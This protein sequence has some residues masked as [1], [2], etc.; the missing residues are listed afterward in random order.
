MSPI[1]FARAWLPVAMALGAIALGACGGGGTSKD[2]GAL[3]TIDAPASIEVTSPAF[4]DGAAIPRANTCDG[5]GGPPTIRW[6]AVPAAA[7][8]VAVVVDDPDAPRGTFR[9]W[10]AYDIP[11]SARG[12]AS[13]QH[14]GTEVGNDGGKP[15]YTGPCPPKG[16][17]PHHY[18]FRLFALDVPRLDLG[19]NA[20]VADVET[21][22]S[23]HAIAQ[24]E[25]IGT[26]E[27]K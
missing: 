20:K 25:L 2:T 24:G 14:I 21:A 26:Y 3:Q 9:H 13:G 23:R 5:T 4:V 12:I 19:A 22:A 1:T 7:K 16:N 18:H 6:T 15:G 10:G 17:G 27:R 11:A 8:T